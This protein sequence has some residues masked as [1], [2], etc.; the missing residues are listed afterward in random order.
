VIDL[1]D[2]LAFAAGF[3]PGSVCFTLGNSFATYVGW[4]VPWGAPVSL[5]GETPDQVADAQRELARIGFGRPV[6]AAAGKLLDWGADQPM[7][8]IRLA[9]FG[10]LADLL[11]RPGPSPEQAPAGPVVLDVRRRLEWEESH[12][13]GATHI[14]FFDLADRLSDVPPGEVWVHCQSGYRA[15]IAASLLCAGGRQVVSVT[16]HFSIAAAAGLSLEQG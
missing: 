15:M 14:P 4:T 7:A 3:L 16:V 8:A 11:A 5:L 10:D 12:V 6:A 13:V 9:K 1:R 2:R